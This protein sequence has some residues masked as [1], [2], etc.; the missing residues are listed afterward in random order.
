MMK[1]R[2]FLLLLVLLLPALTGCDAVV[3]EL[4]GTGGGNEIVF[5]GDRVTL[6]GSGASAEG[7]SVTIH[8]GGTYTLSG[9]LD[10]GRLTVET[11]GSV[12]LILAGVDMTCTT[13][14]PIYIKQA[15]NVTVQLKDGTE[16]TLTDGAEYVYAD[17]Q[18]EPD[19]ALFSECDLTLS[20]GGSLTVNANY[21]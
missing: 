13:F 9:R 21:A 3:G 11:A 2:F 20:G 19:A 12:T 14:A 15:E 6:T 10:D 7:C 18:T 8:Q 1:Q 5:A 4:T 17:G 16:N